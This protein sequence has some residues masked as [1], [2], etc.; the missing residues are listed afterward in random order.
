MRRLTK[1]A[2]AVGAALLV[3]GAAAMVLGQDDYELRV[4]MPTADGTFKGGKVVVAGETIGEIVDVSV[5]DGK[6]LVTASIDDA[7]APL[8][9]GTTARI[10]WESVVGGRML[11]LRPGPMSNPE[12]PSGKTIVSTAERV[13][14]DH[15]LATLDE[16]TRKKVQTL[17]GELNSTLSGRENDVKATIKT[18]GPTIAALGEVMRAVGEDGPAIRDLVKRL[19]AMTSVLAERDVDLGRTVN[20]LG[21]LTSVTADKQAALKAGLSELPAT[22]HRAKSTLDGVPE[23]VDAT[24]PLLQKLRPATARLPETARN[25]SPVL[26]ELRPTVASLRPTLGAARSLLGYTP[27]LLD[28]AHATVPDVTKALTTL[29]PAVSFLR[30]YTPELTGWLTNWTS[31]FSN[32]TSGNHARLL[33]PEGASSLTDVHTA[34]PPGIKRDPRPAPGSIAG[35]PWVDANGDGVR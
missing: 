9:A 19:H 27:G 32:Q 6:A 13:E 35:Q 16:P 11:E 33:I 17:V 34:L 21:R 26:R 12:L 8:R 18:A 2:A 30:P 4:L 29:Q 14:V 15:L 20:H 7:A 24:V 23:A 5:S 22:V 10:S 1:L 25:L 28:S 31:L 3:V